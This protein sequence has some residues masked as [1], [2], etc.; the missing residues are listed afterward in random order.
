MTTVYIVYKRESNG[1]DEV[2]EVW[3]TKRLAELRIKEL[4]KISHDCVHFSDEITLNERS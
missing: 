4:D 3:S 1:H 2:L